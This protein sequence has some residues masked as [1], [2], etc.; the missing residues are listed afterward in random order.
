ML[1]MLISNCPTL[2]PFTFRIITKTGMQN[3]IQHSMVNG[4][5]GSDGHTMGVTDSSS[6]G[7]FDPTS[8]RSVHNLAANTDRRPFEDLMKKTCE[9]IFMA[10]CLKFNGFFSMGG[11]GGGG[12][13]QR[14]EIFISSLLLRH[15]QIAST[16]GL[17][18]AE[19]MLKNNDVRQFD[20]I[21]VGGAIFPTMSFFNHSCY[22]NAQRLG[23]QNVQVVRILRSVVRGEEINI[24]YGFDFYANTREERQR[25]AN[26]QY[27]F[28]CQCQACCENWPQ[29]NELLGRQRQMRV[30]VTQELSEELGRQMAAYK[31][32][33]DFLLKLD[34]TTAMPIFKN[35]LM[36][37]NEVV[38]HPDPR[39]I[40]CEEAYK[41]CLWLENR[42]YR[43]KGG[44]AHDDRGPL[45][46]AGSTALRNQR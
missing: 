10:K 20:I 7:L 25:R 28:D 21:P 5:G 24:D 4:G 17:E 33:M 22:P 15:L 32:G 14:A 3:L 8:Y 19:C 6:R 2:F 46:G 18:M 44:P 1:R 43:V 31:I 27:F 38:E 12:D 36:V 26:Q 9:A 30:R 35:Y 13:T 40:D 45:V 41:Q 29:Y 23:Y 11:G 39:Y 16:N 37:M 34:I 42:G